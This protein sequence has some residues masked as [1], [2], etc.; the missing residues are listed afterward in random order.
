MAITVSG[1]NYTQ[2]SSCDTTTSG[3]TWSGVDTPDSADKKEGA[4]SLCGTLKAAGNNDT[5]FEPT[6]AVDLS[7]TKHVRFWFLITSGSLVNTYANG[8]IQFWASDGTNTGYWYVG[9]R[10]TYPGGWYNFVVDVSKAVDAGTKPTNM[11]AITSMGTRHNLTG[12]G[13]N[14][15]NTWIDNLCV[16]DGL[17][18]YGDDAG[19]YY[20]FED[21]YA[22]ENNPSTGGW[23]ILTRKAGIYCLTGSIEF[24]DSGG[25]SGTKFQ[26]KS[27][28]V[29][30]ENRPNK[31][32][33]LSNINTNLMNFTIVDNGTGTTEFILG[34]KS[35]TQGIEG[36]TIR[37][38]DT[39]QI[40]K[41]D[42]DASTDTDVDYFKL[43]GSTFLDADSIS[44]PATATNVEV[45]NCNFE[46][47]GIII[48]STCVMKYCNFISANSDAMTISST[49]FNVMDCNF[50]SP[51]SHG[52]EVTATGTYVFNNLQF[53]GTGAS[54]PYD[55]ENTTAGLVTIQNTNDSNTAYYE[56]TGGGTTD[57]QSAVTLKV[58]I[59]DPSG[60]AIVGARVL[61]EAGDG[62]GSAPFEESV[63]IT[64]V[65]TTATVT[66]TAHG[67][68]TGQMVNIRGANQ[69]EYNGAG[70]VITKIGADSYSYQVSGTPATPATGTI[71]STQCFMSEL[72]ITGGIAE[73]SFNAAGTQTYRG[74]V[75]K[76]SASPYWRDVTF[77]GADCSGGLDIPIQMELDE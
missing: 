12:V 43:Y 49:T 60:N 8:G 2:I 45:L 1:K 70:K 4:A 16:C 21:I 32:G 24:G 5:T 47:C 20:D 9:G 42:I 64:R 22:V 14:V 39:T 61:M 38:Q 56:N 75:A 77:S 29:I 59:K 69:P 50:I 3:G 26:A 36:C 54:G 15:D 57:I 17:I 53:S 23:G 62:T 18:T 46:S 25:T 19:G 73:E 13:K 31:D 71:T 72:T 28:V 30:F 48:P 6:G 66:H 51:T 76:S 67:L 74:R 55:V 11:N 35:G 44:L 41:F 33:T 34:S 37:V 27:Q 68:S 65:D 58:T 63:T 52:V 40:A 7:G 10:D